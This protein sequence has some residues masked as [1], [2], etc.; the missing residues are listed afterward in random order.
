[1]YFNNRTPFD[2]SACYSDGVILYKY[3][4]YYYYYYH[5]AA[6]GVMI[7]GRKVINC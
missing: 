1:M 2:A 6:L 3:Y 4:Y 7:A 5:Y